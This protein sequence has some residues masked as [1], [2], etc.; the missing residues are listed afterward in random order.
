MI[1]K[2][3]IVILFTILSLLKYVSSENKLIFA[4]EIHRHGA[5]SP[6]SGV[7]NEKD[8]FGEN[9]ISNGELSNVGKRQLYLLGN[10]VRKRYMEKFNLLSKNYNPQEIFIQSTDYNRSIE[11]IYSFIQ[12]L[13]PN[14]TGKVINE[15]IS[16]NTNITY[17]P[18]INIK[19]KNGFENILK[20]DF[21]NGNNY[22]LPF[23][24]DILPV[25]I[26]NSIDDQFQL[27]STNICPKLSEQYEKVHQNETI[28]NFAKK[29]KENTKDIFIEIEKNFTD[30]N[31]IKN[32]DFL[33]DYWT[34]YRYEDNLVCN[35]L[36]QRNFSSFKEKYND[37]NLNL[38]TLIKDAK[39]FLRED[40]FLSNKNTYKAVFSSSSIL[41]DLVNWMERAINAVN[42]I[43][44]TNSSYKKYVIYSANDLSIEAL[45][46]FMNL[47]L[48]VKMDYIDF[49]ERRAFELYHNNSDNSY[50]INYLKGTNEK[51]NKYSYTF[52]EFKEK[53][54]EK[55]WSKKK[56]NEF[57]FKK[58]KDKYNI[59]I[60]GATIMVILSV[61]DGVLI[62]LFILFC[63]KKK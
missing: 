32:N 14:G 5:S 22:A 6:F 45:E 59:N 33:D 16:N 31:K 41:F 20:E 21:F 39:Q 15:K 40:Y 9:W 27:L 50:K 28:K 61:F 8:L 57:C 1:K 35:N 7:K 46:R 12:G 30:N 26:L 53:I 62:V 42:N 11:S 52:K 49:A 10:S 37:S 44:S 2:I 51:K 24:M 38:N 13:Y 34:L 23:N 3:E 48:F 58:D 29:L 54:Q 4:F 55:A 43:N 17:P 19:Y 56:I 63:A 47:Y 36:D 18:N 25:H 60:T